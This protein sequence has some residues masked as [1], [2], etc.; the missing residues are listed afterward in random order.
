M[1]LHLALRNYNL[2][3]VKRRSFLKSLAAAS[4]A[5][6]AGPRLAHASL[7]AAKITKIRI[8][9]P[10]TLNQTFA[11]SNAVVQIDTDIGITGTGEGGT[12]DT[13]EQCAGTLI[14]KDPFRIEQLWQEMYMVWFYAPGREKIHALGALDMA[15]WD[16]KGK[17]LKLPLHQ[18][19]GGSARDYC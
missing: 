4:V 2:C 18:M 5:G 12:R 7:P 19:L 3:D 17:A 13:L 10:P 9:Y 14:G 16:I 15:L 6:A 11:Q 8:Y 1:D